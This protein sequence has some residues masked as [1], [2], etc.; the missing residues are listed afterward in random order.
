MEPSFHED[1]FFVGQ[2]CSVTT[3]HL[4][5]QPTFSQTVHGNKRRT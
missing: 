1:G 2:A 5:M 3:A 4:Q